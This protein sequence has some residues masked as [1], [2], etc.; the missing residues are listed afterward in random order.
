MEFEPAD[1]PPHPHE[2]EVVFDG[3]FE[4]GGDLADAE[5]GEIGCRGGFTH[6]S[7]MI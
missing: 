1:L 6:E 5:F 4:R 7:R 2:R 3:A